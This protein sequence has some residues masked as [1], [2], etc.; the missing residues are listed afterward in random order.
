M[1][2]RLKKNLKTLVTFFYK[3]KNAFQPP[4]K[5][6][7]LH[8]G[9]C[10]ST[11]LSSLF[12]NDQ[13]FQ[14]DGEAIQFYYKRN[15]KKGGRFPFDTNPL[16]FLLNLAKKSGKP[17]HGV[18]IKA[19]STQDF[20]L[21]QMPSTWEEFTDWAL[22]NNYKLILLYR[23]DVLR[24][25]VSSLLAYKYDLWHINSKLNK[26]VLDKR[27]LI[28][29]DNVYTELGISLTEL[30]HVRDRFNDF[31]K[32]Q[33]KSGV[34]VL[35]YERDILKNPNYAYDKTMAYLGLDPVQTYTSHKRVNPESLKELIENFDE[36]YEY[37]QKTPY[38]NLIN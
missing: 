32:K 18:E 37:L 16:G 17:Y 28:N 33:G 25:V 30:L 24:Q 8:T 9:R 31:C 27:I 23:D 13:R 19:L 3:I 11:V 2:T 20:S 1:I 34:L 29:V 5:I 15:Q 12:E 6:I 7:L 4:Q 26:N 38:A 22:K 21:E 14:W 10:G 35:N 36:V